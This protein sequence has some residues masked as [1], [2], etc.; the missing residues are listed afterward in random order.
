M[1]PA[2]RQLIAGACFALAALC[3]LAQ[4]PAKVL[5]P[6][7]N[8]GP[9][10]QSIVQFVVDVTTNGSPNY[11]S[12]DQRIAVFDGDGTLW[13]EKPAYFQLL[14]EMDRIRQLA[15][16]HPE[17]SSQYPYTAVLDNDVNTLLASGQKDLLDLV[18]ATHTGITT[19][20]FEQLVL[21]WLAGAQHP[22]FKRPYTD[23]VYQPMLE[24]ID[25]LRANDFKIFVVSS[26]GVEFTRPFA[27]YLYSIPP[28]QVIGSS[29]ETQFQ[30]RGGKP[31]LVLLPKVDFVDDG[32]GKPVA[33][34]RFIGR[35][36]VFAIGNSDG[37]REML[38][39]VATNPRYFVALVHHTDAE[40][41][42]RYDRNLPI[43]KLDR[44][45][46]EATSRG[47]SLIDMKKDWNKV[48]PPQANQ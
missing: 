18:A 47:W 38:Q 19:D 12:S 1:R 46:D 20:Q 27:Q 31:A 34:Q 45:L 9:V 8:P 43:D 32:P 36:P 10:K 4:E 6:S 24:L 14:F 22:R 48:F 13:A 7:W 39:W 5:M 28:E 25:Y 21:E 26:A 41:E 16:G 2:L 44:A 11:L 30:L 35:R 23:L 15:S 40:R 3:C 17:W 37:D 29:I 33:I 42:W